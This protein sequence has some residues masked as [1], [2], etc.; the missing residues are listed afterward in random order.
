[1]KTQDEYRQF[2]TMKLMR[3]RSAATKANAYYSGTQSLQFLDPE[4]ARMM[5]GRLA[6]LNINFARLAVDT[7]ESRI[8]VSGFATTPG[9]ASDAAL[10]ELWQASNMD[11][12][13]QQAHLDALIFGRAF[14]LAWVGADGR[15]TLSAESPLQ[16]AVHRDPV[17]RETTAAI[18]QWRDDEGYTHALLFTQGEIS[19]F[20]S[21]SQ[22]TLDPMF[23][24]Q[25][26]TYGEAFNLVRTD[27]NPLGIVPMVALVNRPRLQA[28][29]GE[30]ELMDLMPLLDGISKLATD[31]MVSSEYSASPRRYVTGIAP[32]DATQAQ[33]DELADTIKNRWERAHA[34]KF[35]IAPSAETKFG[36]FET[37]TLQNY[38]GAIEMMSAQI[39]AIAS[40]PPQYLSLLNSNPT[41]AD[42]I[43]SSESRL[44]MKAKR[45]QQI[46]S[47][48]YE[49]L[50]RIAVL[51]RDGQ[52]DARLQDM[53]TLWVSAET[54]TIAQTADAETKLF[55]AGVIDQ[56]TALAALDYSPQEIDRIINS[57]Q[58]NGAIA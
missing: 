43:R 2:L 29:D 55:A 28:P 7:L 13:S 31:L 17:T 5:N 47:G 52:P 46:W 38:I 37:P 36:Q 21:S 33:M 8:Q 25:P 12:Q 14:Y 32:T 51:I 16:C 23:T 4:I 11:E 24:T 3:Q 27:V 57:T 44:T 9:G 1:M 20:I 40:L 18:K 26:A 53:E 34:A 54:T 30:S 58:T 39:A 42:A 15:P 6:T 35:L 45:R 41:S 10:W 49:E 48:A 19:E 50:M 22:F 56:R